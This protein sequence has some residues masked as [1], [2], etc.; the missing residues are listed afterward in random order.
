LVLFLENKKK[1][2]LILIHNINVIFLNFYK[3]F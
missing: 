2:W 1:L 3:Y